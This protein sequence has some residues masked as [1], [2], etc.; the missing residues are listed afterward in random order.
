MREVRDTA[1]R[2]LRLEAQALT[3]AADSFDHRAF[4][5]A[6]DILRGAIGPILTT[7]VGTSGIVARKIAATFT[8]TGSRAVFLHPSDALHG[9]LG[10][11]RRHDVVIMVSNS[12]KTDELI[13]ALPYFQAREVQIVAVVGNTD[14]PLGRSADV[15]LDASVEVEAC[16]LGLAPTSS[17]TLAMAVGDALAVG[18]MTLKDIDAADFARN[19]PSGRLG[20]R[21]T[22][23]V[24]DLMQPLEALGTV[25]RDSP[26][27]EVVARISSSGVGAALVVESGRLVG[28]VTDGDVRRGVAAVGDRSLLDVTADELMTSQPDTVGP[29]SSAY[30]ALL[31]MEQRPSQI[32]VLPVVRDNSPV[33][34]VRLHDLIRS[35]L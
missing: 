4:A 3:A 32:S 16:P 27:L 11:L 26:L 12:G 2:V 31:T 5:D 24:A 9:Q 34:L 14:S 33:G 15:T 25:A 7:G 22:L 8:S 29:E 19:H 21:L 6:V 28:L 35:G 30:E 23:T 18:V 17:T 10:L 1:A 20:R 13:A